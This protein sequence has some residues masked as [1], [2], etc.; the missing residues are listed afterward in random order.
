MPT[1]RRFRGIP[2]EGG[3]SR[4]QLSLDGR[5]LFVGNSWFSSWDQRYYPKL[6]EQGSIIA[7]VHI[8]VNSAGS[9]TLDE[10]FCIQLSGLFFYSVFCIV[11][12]HT[13]RHKAIR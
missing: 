2:F 8:N 9:M 12:N 10:N 7:L 1:R 6:Q 4:L 13:F 3:P 5:R 11:K